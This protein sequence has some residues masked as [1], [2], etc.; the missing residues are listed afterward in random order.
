[1]DHPPKQQISPLSL[2]L[3]HHFL[4]FSTGAC[5]IFFLLLLLPFFFCLLRL[6]D[7]S[8]FKLRVVL[9]V[10]WWRRRLMDVMM[11]AVESQRHGRARHDDDCFVG[12]CCCWVYSLSLCLSQ[13]LSNNNSKVL[14]ALERET[15][16][17]SRNP[18]WVVAFPCVF[19]SI[20]FINKFFSWGQEGK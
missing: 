12:Y 11:M 20:F 16:N 19:N 14:R 3:W 1:M 8:W 9:W 13:A 7:L 2:L 5:I 4:G 18:W 6:L 10:W 15:I 17:S